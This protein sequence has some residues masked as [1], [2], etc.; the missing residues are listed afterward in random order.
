V[1][2][3]NFLPRTG[4]LVLGSDWPLFG[5]I[6][7]T[8]S[9]DSGPV[10]GLPHPLTRTVILILNLILSTS[11]YQTIAPTN[12]RRICKI[13]QSPSRPPGYLRLPTQGGSYHDL[14]LGSATCY[15]RLSRP[16][17]E[18]NARESSLTTYIAAS[19]SFLLVLPQKH[20]ISSSLSV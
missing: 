16:F 20:S 4:D 7:R 8:Q 14:S 12:A 1:Q 11:R 6:A 13:R 3:E 18:S 19:L 10:V 17:Y 9:G 5:P 2:V 15:L